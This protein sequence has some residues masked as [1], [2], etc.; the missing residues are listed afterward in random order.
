MNIVDEK[1]DELPAILDIYNDAVANT[2]AIWNEVT[3]DLANRCDWLRP[4]Q[5][6]GYPVLVAH[7]HDGHAICQGRFGRHCGS[8]P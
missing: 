6:Q 2:T 4:R 5:E 1:D 8:T 7:D 3:V